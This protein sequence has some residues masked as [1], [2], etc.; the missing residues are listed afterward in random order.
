LKATYLNRS[1]PCHPSITITTI[2]TA[3]A[4]DAD[5]TMALAVVAEDVDVVTMI[6][7]I[8]IT[9]MTTTLLI[10]TNNKPLLPLPLAGGLPLQLM[11]LPS[12]KTN[13][14]R[15]VDGPL[16]PRLVLV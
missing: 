2:I 13:L 4:E 6:T 9:I 10:T 5:M 14:K 7:T 1:S 3:Q 15:T 8:I 16:V 11:P 12:L